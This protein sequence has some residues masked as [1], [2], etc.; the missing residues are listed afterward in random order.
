MLSQLDSRLKRSLNGLEG[1]VVFV[2][3]VGLVGEHVM[4]L[5]VMFE[6]WNVNADIAILVPKFLRFLFWNRRKPNIYKPRSLACLLVLNNR[7]LVYA[8]SST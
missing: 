2:R 1:I 4:V 5:L 8:A 7:N 3:C 6:F